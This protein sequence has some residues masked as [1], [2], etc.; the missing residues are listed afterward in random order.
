[1]FILRKKI[2]KKNQLKVY[3][4]DEDFWVIGAERRV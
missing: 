3:K 1:M 4:K 2:L